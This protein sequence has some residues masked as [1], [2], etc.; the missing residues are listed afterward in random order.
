MSYKNSEQLHLYAQNFNETFPFQLLAS[1][2]AKNRA[3]T[4]DY[5]RRR[6]YQYT[7]LEYILEGRGY[8]EINNQR[9]HLKKG[10]VYIL[11]RGYDH[12]YYPEK[13]DP[14][15]KIFITV[16]GLLV[17][18]LFTAYGLKQI[19]YLEQTDAFSLFKKLHELYGSKDSFL[20]RKAAVLFHQLLMHFFTIKGNASPAHSTLVAKVKEYIDTH[21]E[22][23]IKLNEMCK[24]LNVSEHQVIRGFKKELDTTPYNYLMLR[25]LELAKFLLITTSMRIK[26]IA[27]RLQFADQYYFSNFFKKKNKVS[28]VQFRR[29]HCEK[30]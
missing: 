6:K 10:D 29:L 20:H 26:E 5:Y 24:E 18:Q 13:K 15:R 8:L 7:N 9:W 19:F 17:D 1:Q 30:K 12:Y 3:T 4:K 16:D 25:R 23:K 27:V 14:W 2:S 22:E 28:P 21:L 11:H